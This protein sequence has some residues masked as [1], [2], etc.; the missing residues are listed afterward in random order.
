[1]FYLVNL[2]DNRI[3][4]CD[5]EKFRLK[6]MTKPKDK[7]ATNQNYSMIVYLKDQ[8]A[9]VKNVNKRNYVGLSQLHLSVEKTINFSL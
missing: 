2:A 7:I 9:F 3:E 5:A 8:K 6:N 4:N 1:M